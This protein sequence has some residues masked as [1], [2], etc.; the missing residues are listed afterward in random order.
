MPASLNRIASAI[1]LDQWEQIGDDTNIA[2]PDVKGKVIVFKT[3]PLYY[4][5]SKLRQ[6]VDIPSIYEVIDQ[7]FKNKENESVLSEN[8]LPEDIL[9][10]N[11]IRRYF[12]NKVMMKHLKNK[13]IGKF[14]RELEIMFEDE[15]FLCEDHIKI[16]VKLPQFYNYETQTVDIFNQHSSLQKARGSYLVDS[17]YKFVGSTQKNTTRKKYKAFYWAAPDKTL[18]TVTTDIQEKALSCWEYLAEKGEIGIR[19]NA[20]VGTMIG[21]DF[22]VYQLGKTYELYDPEDK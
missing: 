3:D 10:A 20:S 6:N 8:I 14:E 22:Y 19:G 7:I 4:V 12:K 15:K 2:Y 17:T 21:G 1:A 5:C 11:T 18:L 13:P 9:E 16:L